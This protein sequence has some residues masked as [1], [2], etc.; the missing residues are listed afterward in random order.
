MKRYISAILIPCLLLQLFGC[1]SFREV[2]MDDLQKYTGPN[3]V[4]LI[5]TEKETIIKRQLSGDLQVRWETSDSSV[6]INSTELI[7]DNN[8]V[9]PVSN[10]S[11]IM[12]EKINSVEIEEYDNLKTLGLTFGIIL[13]AIIIIAAATFDMSMSWGNGTL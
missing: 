9:K 8:S 5:T 13:T 2:T 7:K 3:E 4:K 12:F 1:Y 6:V 11:E 10:K